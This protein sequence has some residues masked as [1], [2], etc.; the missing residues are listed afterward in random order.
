[1]QMSVAT[2]LPNL[3][4]VLLVLL[5]SLTAFV[6]GCNQIS[7]GNARLKPAQASLHACCTNME[8]YPRWYVEMARTVAPALGTVLS[9]VAWRSGYLK[10][11]PAAQDAIMDILQPL[12]IVLVSSKGRRSGQM[13]PGLF[14]HAAVYVGTEQE[15]QRLGIWASSKV[16]PHAAKIRSG[17]VFIE[18]DADGVHLS[19]ASIVLNTDAVAILRPRFTGLKQRRKTALDFFSA[20]GM[21]FDFLF[22]VDS[23]DCTFCT[24]LIHRVMPQLD[25]P[26]MEIYGVRTIMPDSL[27]VSAIR[28]KPNLAVVG[29]IKGDRNGWRQA[30]VGDLAKDIGQ[31]WADRQR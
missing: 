25:L 18:A 11:K 16:Q 13:I 22:D 5:L 1:M 17:H 28:R 10:S 6:Q 24:E 15:L 27:A 31:N 29:Y 12:D 30:S 19:P 21:K 3:R 9:H 23:P 26:I 20:M 14:G 4:R 8:E 7:T 2:S